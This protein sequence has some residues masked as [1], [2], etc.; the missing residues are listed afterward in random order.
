[1]RSSAKHLIAYEARRNKSSETKAPAVFRVTDKLRPHL[2]MLMGNGGFR[3]LLA[4]ALTLA[5]E[6]VQWL[7][8]VHVKADGTLEGL[9]ELHAQLAPAEFL[10]G[11]VALLTQLLGLLVAFIGPDLTSRLVGEI[12][13]RFPLDVMYLGNGVDNEKTE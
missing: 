8:A 7:R 12:W 2:A 5:N 6:E 4:R 1:M 9:E 10:E 11:D 13:P 3:A